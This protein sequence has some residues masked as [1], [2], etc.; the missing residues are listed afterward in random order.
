MLKVNC[1]HCDE[2]H[3]ISVRELPREIAEYCC[4]ERRRRDRDELL[5]ADGRAHTFGGGGGTVRSQRERFG[6]SGWLRLPIP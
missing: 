3:E 2:V 6:W 4:G 5:D 1:L